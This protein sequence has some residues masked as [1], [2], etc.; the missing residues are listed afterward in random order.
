MF[1]LF[2]ILHGLFQEAK[3]DEAEEGAAA[4]AENG[5]GDA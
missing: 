5:Q 1:W 3:P 4:A 2:V